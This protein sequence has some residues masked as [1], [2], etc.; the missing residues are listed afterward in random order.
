[1]TPSQEPHKGISSRGH[2]ASLAEATPA[3]QQAGRRDE[4]EFRADLENL[5]YCVRGGCS[6]TASRRS[7]RAL[8]H[9]T[10]AK[11]PSATR[12]EPATAG[13]EVVARGC[14]SAQSESYDVAGEQHARC[15]V[16]S[17]GSLDSELLALISQGD[18]AALGLIYDR[19][20]GAVWRVALHFSESATAAE[21]VVSAV[22]LGLW[23]DP[24]PNHETSLP[25]RLLSSVRRE[26]LDSQKVP[27][28]EQMSTDA[29]RRERPLMAEANEAIDRL[30]RSFDLADSDFFCECGHTSCKERVTL[31]RAEYASL[32]EESRPLI[33]AAHADRESAAAMELHELRGQVHRLQGSLASRVNIGQAKG[34]L[35]ERH[36]MTPDD[37]FEALRQRARDQRRSL[38]E[39]CLQ[40]IAWAGIPN[41]G[42]S[43]PAPSAPSRP[44]RESYGR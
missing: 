40:I 44:S 19:H 21:R 41:E 32:R 38:D 17:G 39:V 24:A 30:H 11:P 3:L 26:S 18:L 43:E 1:M 16:R 8:T 25:A 35:I 5:R 10:R 29:D 13:T 7:E 31:N 42:R 12:S 20:I 4:H 14:V 15:R 33:A 22:F 23:R 34:V 28:G 36:G 2:S 37:A 6:A 27:R 9:R